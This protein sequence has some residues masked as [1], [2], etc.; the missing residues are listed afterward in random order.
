[1]GTTIRRIRI[2][3]ASRLRA[4]RLAALADAPTAFGT[5]LAEARRKPPAHWEQ[6]ARDA[7]TSHAYA[8]FVAEEDRRWHGLAGGIHERPDTVELVSM[9]VE[10]CRR[11]SGIGAALVEAVVAWARGLDA[12]RVTLWVTDVNHGA[13]SLYRRQGFEETGQTQPLPSHPELQEVL[14]A[15]DL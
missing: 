3:E 15:R 7:A 13:K 10:P 11:R 4:L 8:L 12:R 5:T 1:M 9:W 6:L 14:M 2:D